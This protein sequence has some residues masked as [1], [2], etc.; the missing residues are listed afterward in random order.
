[1]PARYMLIAAEEQMEWVP[2]SIALKQPSPAASQQD[3]CPA[4]PMA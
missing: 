1:M 2:M 3:G 4:S